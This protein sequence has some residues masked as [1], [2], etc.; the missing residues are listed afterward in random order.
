MK[1]L[2]SLDYLRSFSMLYIVGYW[3]LFNYTDAF[4]Q[5]SNA[6]TYTM[7]LIV[8]GLFVLISGF[9]IGRREVKPTD[10]S[11]S[12]VGFYKKKLME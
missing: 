12:I 5:Y 6:V 11:S 9:L 8:L 2:K 4:P 10:N 3:H 7:T 1:K